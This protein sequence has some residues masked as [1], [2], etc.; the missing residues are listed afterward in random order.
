MSAELQ[1]E[2]DE[3]GVRFRVGSSGEEQPVDRWHAQEVISPPNGRPAHI[4]PL[5]RL[6]DEERAGR[7]D[8]RTVEVP[9]Q[10]IAEM[11]LRQLSGLGLPPRADVSIALTSKGSLG[12]PDFHVN[13]RYVGFDGI[14]L[15][16]VFRKGALLEFGGRKTILPDP[17]YGIINGIDKLNS[18]PEQDAATRMLAWGSITEKLPDGLE[19]DDYLKSFRISVASSF[20]LQPFTNKDGEPDFDPVLGKIQTFTD[21]V[22]EEAARFTPSLPEARAKE[23]GK[24]FRRLSKLK[25]Q[26]ALGA[27]T[28]VVLAPEILPAVQQVKDAQSREVTDHRRFLQNPSGYLREALEEASIEAELDSVFFDEGLSERVRGLGIWEPKVLPWIKRSAEAWLPPETVGL[29]IDSESVAVPPERIPELKG[30]IRDAIAQGRPTVDFEGHSI[31]A[32]P[33]T[34]EALDRV[35]EERKLSGKPSRETEEKEGKHGKQV[36]LI[37]ENLE[38]L[39]YQ[40]Q[41]QKRKGLT[42]SLP[43][44]LKSKLLRHQE[45][46]LHWLQE[47]WMEGST[48][49][50]LADDMGL[51]KTLQA[52]AFLSCLQE[53]REATGGNPGPLLVV[54]PTGLLQNWI[55]EHDKHLYEPGLGEPL[56]AYGKGLREIRLSQSP[57]HRSGAPALDIAKLREADWVLTTYETLR[58]Y[59]H[60][61]ARVHWVVAVFDESQK[62]KNPAAGVTHAALTMKIDFTLMMTGTPVE[63]R[64]ADIW[65]MI[66][67]AQPGRLGSLKEF[68]QQYEKEEQQ[69]HLKELKVMLTERRQG[70]EIMLRRMKED[71]LNGLPKR[72]L[73]VQP[74]T[75]PTKQ[76]EAY[77]E[78]IENARRDGPILKVLQNLRAVSLHPDAEFDEDL[79][80]YIQDSARLAET[81]RILDGVRDRREKALLFCEAIA[82]QEFLAEALPKKYRMPG[83][84]QIINGNVPGHKRKG[85]VDN[86]QGRPG[87]DVM[88]LSPRAGGVGL[89]LTAANHVIHLSRWWNPAVEDQCTDRAL[90]IGHQKPVHIYLPIA[91]HPQYGDSSFDV[92]LDHLLSRKRQLSRELLAPV[93]ATKRDLDELYHSTTN[94]FSTDSAR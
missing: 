30:R 34:L 19:A 31:P 26:H 82:M 64:P 48:G 3:S 70:P 87:F 13:Y 45:Q 41:G 81:F 62:I 35:E 46:A 24:R 57:E 61:F 53:T 75:M 77:R 85:F 15:A 43:R 10:A 50:L 44:N 71:H 1:L 54:A 60:S 72:H 92:K 56:E 4:G 20:T 39:G 94:E 58:D 5:L 18:T 12:S 83:P 51:G 27:N 78:V 79:E 67:G 63:N 86:F 93:G 14:P 73:H 37:Q 29:K 74:C 55:A 90:R 21:D 76:A 8:E 89:T 22:G 52:L 69:E 6:L 9:W 36:L 32:T 80:S 66:D 25:P 49:A 7:P 23:F 84:L 11:S 42:G 47:H 65:P 91:R 59:Q 16:R 17:L 2:H 88:V 38:E 28:F 33:E 40:A 68:S